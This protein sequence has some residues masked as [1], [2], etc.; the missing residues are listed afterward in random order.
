[1][2]RASVPEMVVPYGDPRFRYWQAYFDSGEYLVGKWANS[3]ELGC[4]C[5]GEITYLDATVRRRL[6]RSRR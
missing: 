1:M 3:L 5:L 2:Y 4:D 6:R